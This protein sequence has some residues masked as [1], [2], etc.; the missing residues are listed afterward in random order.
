[1]VKRTYIPIREDADREP[2]LREMLSDPIVAALMRADG[3]DPAKLRVALNRI[4]GEIGRRRS[5]SGDPEPPPRR[6]LD[7][8]PVR[9]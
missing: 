6:V 3:V 2:T 9:L 1:M 5:I 7:C 8:L 4:A